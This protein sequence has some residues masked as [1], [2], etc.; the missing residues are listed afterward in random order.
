VGKFMVNNAPNIEMYR[1]EIK[2]V[3]EIP[4]GTMTW[5]VVEAPWFPQCPVCD[6]PPCSS[7]KDVEDARSH[8]LRGLH[9]PG[10]Y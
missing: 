2:K 6:D 10:D 9:G 5:T 3:R 4:W 8:V 1:G 7:F